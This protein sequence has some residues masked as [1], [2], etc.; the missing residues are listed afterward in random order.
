MVITDAGA[1]TKYSNYYREGTLVVIMQDDME[2]DATK[3]VIEM[4]HSDL[5]NIGL[6][7]QGHIVGSFGR[8]AKRV[9]WSTSQGEC[10]AAVGGEELGQMIAARYTEVF[11]AKRSL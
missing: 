1:N 2:K 9:S 4:E 8:R 6:S 7:G 5:D 10:L 11:M 3:R